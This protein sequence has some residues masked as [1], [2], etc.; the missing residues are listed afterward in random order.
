[1]TFLSPLWLIGLVPWAAV[2][3][4]L[5]WGRRR[6]QWVPFL[7]FWIGPVQGPRP[8]RRLAA[9]PVSLAAALLAP[10]LALLAAAGPRIAGAGAR[11]GPVTIIVDAGASMSARGAAAAR[12]VETAHLV[13]EE[14]LKVGPQTPL[15]VY[16]VAGSAA[17]PRRSS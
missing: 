4:Y 12:F 2:A 13:G 1:M 3:L 5:L 7:E 17:G 11:G 16:S 6:Q 10:L 9:P 8:K 15:E 14:L